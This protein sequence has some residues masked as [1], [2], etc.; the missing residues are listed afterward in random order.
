MWPWGETVTCVERAVSVCS[1]IIDELIAYI[2]QL[3]ILID[4]S[5]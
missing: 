5:E 1:L 4:F 3:Y 2:L